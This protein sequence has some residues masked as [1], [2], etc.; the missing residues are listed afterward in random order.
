[1]KSLA[2]LLTSPTDDYYYCSS[3]KHLWTVQRGKNEPPVMI[4]DPT[5]APASQR[6]SHR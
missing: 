4:S 6:I 2:D 1:M 3:C 5:P